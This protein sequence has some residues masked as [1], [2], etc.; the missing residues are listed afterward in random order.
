MASVGPNSPA[1]ASDTAGVG[2]LTWVNPTA[3]Y[4]SDN[5]YTTVNVF[6]AITSQSHYIACTNYGFS[7]P[8]GAT[9]DGIVVEIERKA[10][11][12]AGSKYVVDFVV[13]LIKGG[14]I[15]GSNLADTV[16]LY[17]TTDT[18]ATYGGST[19]LWGLSWTHT[20]INASNFGVALSVKVAN[21]LKTNTIASI[22]HLR[23][24]V[25]YTTGGGAATSKALLLA[26]N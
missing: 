12:S 20:D 16:T 24:T 4:S 23:I 10:N 15:S 13:K 17:P 6:G 3:V 25:Y 22:D 8:S 5:T 18:I 19:N 9:I 11:N 1:T 14:T 2:T 26:G 21:T 7:I